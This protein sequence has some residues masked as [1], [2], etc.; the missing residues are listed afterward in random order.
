MERKWEQKPGNLLYEDVMS[1]TAAALLKSYQV[2]ISA[3]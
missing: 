2:M 1:G 3:L